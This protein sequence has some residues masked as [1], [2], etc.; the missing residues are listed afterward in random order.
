MTRVKRKPENSR[1]R[2]RTNIEQSEICRCLSFFENRLPLLLTPTRKQAI[3]ET[4][5][6]TAFTTRSMAELVVGGV[7]SFGDYVCTFD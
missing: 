3:N 4:Q 2:K 6:V 1:L 7:M 5:E